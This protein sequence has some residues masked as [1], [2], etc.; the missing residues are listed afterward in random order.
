MGTS[1]GP[2]T[3][4]SGSL[5]VITSIDGCDSTSAEMPWF[6]PVMIV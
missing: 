3:R 1:N 4:P 2:S 6:V 5:L